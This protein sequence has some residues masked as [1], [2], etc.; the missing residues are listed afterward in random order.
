MSE[1]W[2][3]GTDQAAVILSVR[4]GPSVGRTF[5]FTERT[6]CVLGRASDCW[7][8]LPDDD[9]RVS[10]HHCLFDINPPDVRVRDFG[11]LNGT[12]VN[13]EEIGRRRPDQT[14][15]Q[16]VRTAFPERDLAHGDE[17]RIG[18]TLL[19][20]QTVTGATTLKRTRVY[21]AHCGRDAPESADRG[22][23]GD[24]ICG[25]CRKDPRALVRGL[26]SQAASMSRYEVVRELGRGGQGVV[27]LARHLDTGELVALKVLLAEVAV[28]HRARNTFLREIETL[29]GLRHPRIVGYH[30]SGAQGATFYLACE[31]CAYGTLSE[32]LTARGGTLPPAEAVAIAAQV[33][34]GLDHAHTR[35]GLV[36]RDIKPSNILFTAPGASAAGGASGAPAA[37][38]IGDF[39][40]AKAFDQAGLS[41]LTR[42][43]TV[44]GTV[45]YMPRTQVVDYKYARPEVDVWATAATLYRMLTGTTPR[46]FPPH[47]DPVMVLLRDAAVPI[48]DRDPA[49]PRR[50]ADVIDEAL[51]D[52]PRIATTTA[53]SFRQA[54]EAAI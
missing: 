2:A 50:L 15:K 4:E 23:P 37:V 40:L 21:C 20:V 31:F 45:A 53:E 27:H 25:A 7:P 43:G 47:V 46:T 44:A 13:G 51:I 12:F 28:G 18:R 38:K 22:R 11:S 16:A 30:D 41:G 8:R 52:S 29:R 26:L 39:G 5:S 48:R 33:L 9:R 24:I 42:T 19:R 10:R 49:I 35:H 1:D 32:L 17:V 34:D 54:L 36:H 14:P 3:A 6:T